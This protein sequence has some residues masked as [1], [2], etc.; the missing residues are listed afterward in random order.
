MV[1][2]SVMSCSGSCSGSCSCSS[3]MFYVSIYLLFYLSIYL[4]VYLPVY[5][6]ACQRSY[7]A[8]ILQFLNVKTSKTKQFRF[9]KLTTSKTKQFCETSFKSGKLSA[10]LCFT[11]FPLHLSKVLHLPRKSDARSYEVLQLSRKIIS[12]NLKI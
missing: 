10:K 8:T 2:C 9:W 7:F 1:W 12:A 4:S 3:M 5:Q 6:Q 11:M